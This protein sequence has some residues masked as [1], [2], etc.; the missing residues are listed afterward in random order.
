MQSSEAYQ[1]I[2]SA[3]RLLIWQV[4]SSM[5]RQS[6]QERYFSGEY[7]NDLAQLES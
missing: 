1:N 2:D 5:T 7:E 3:E 4:N 6:T